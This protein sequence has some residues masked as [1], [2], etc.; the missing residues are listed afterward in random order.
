MWRALEHLTS[1]VTPDGRLVVAIY[2]DEGYTSKL[3]VAIKRIYQKLPAC[4]QPVYV[5]GIGTF[6]FLKRLMITLAASLLRLITF[7]NPFVPFMNWFRETRDRGM[8]KWFDLVDWVGGW[9]F[10]VARPEEIFRFFRDRG[11]V[12]TEMTTS[13]GHGCNEFAFRREPND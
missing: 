13:G 2:N 3:W 12:L 1:L 5:L 6:L 11:F 10:E 7:R 4:L 9:P 8:R